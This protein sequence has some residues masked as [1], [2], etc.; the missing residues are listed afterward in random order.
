MLQAELL[1]QVGGITVEKKVLAILKRVME[2]SAMM[3]FNIRGT[4]EK[5]TFKTYK[6]YGV[7]FRKYIV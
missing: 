5:V 3:N 2:Y 1:S 4:K 7:I 6:L